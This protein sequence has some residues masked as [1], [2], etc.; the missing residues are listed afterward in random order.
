MNT[1]STATKDCPRCGGTGHYLFNQIH[2]TICY[3]C[4]GKGVVPVNARIAAPVQRPDCMR[5]A[6]LRDWIG[7]IKLPWRRTQY[8]G[9]QYLTLE[10]FELADAGIIRLTLEGGKIECHKAG[11]IFFPFRTDEG[12]NK[13]DLRTGE[14]WKWDRWGKEIA[15]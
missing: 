14:P 3:G 12:G 6:Q 1:R 4:N 13:F 8:E 9:Y 10:S 5:Y 15:S 2:G 7:K 11:D